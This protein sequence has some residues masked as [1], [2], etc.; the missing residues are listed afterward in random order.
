[1]P[2]DGLQETPLRNR[3][4]AALIAVLTLIASQ[5]AVTPVGAVVGQK[6]VIIV[7]PT[8]AQTDSYRSK[9]DDIATA[10]EAAGA[11][12]V[13]VYSPNAT[14]SAVRAAVDGANIVVYLGHGNG[15]PNPY[16]STELRDRTNGWGLNRTT[17]GG[18]SDD[19]SAQMVYCGEKALLGTLSSS[20]GAA[21][22]TYCTGGPITPAPNW[23]MIYSNACY[24]PGASEGSDPQGPATES[25]AMQR[26][27]NYSYPSLLL[28]GGAYF[29]TDMNN[30]PQQLIDTIL[31]NPG[32]AFGAIAENAN[33]YDLSRQRHYAHPDLSGTRIWIQNT[34]SPTSGNYFFA[35]AG[36][37]DL[38]PSG[39]TVAYTEPDVPSGSTDLIFDSTGYFVPGS[40]GASYVALAP[41][42]LL[43][44]RVAN[45]L[46]G[47]FGAGSPRTFQVTGRGGVPGNAT[48]IT[49]N[50][51]VTAQSAA[52]YVFLGPTPT[53]NPSSSTLNFPLGDSRA[54][55]VTVALGAGGTL[56]ATYVA[57]AGASTHLIFDV[58]GYFVPGSGGASFAPLAPARLL[59][60]RFGTGLSGPFG[61]GGPRT[62]QVTGLGGV[63]GNATAVTGNLTVTAQSK[64][65]YV[66]LGPDPVAS[67]AS[68]TLN[69]PLGDSRANGVTV[70]LGAGGTLSAT[71]VAPAGA[72]THLIFDVTG[73]FVPGSGGASYVALAPARLLDTRAG[74]GLSGP[75]FDGVPRSFQVTG[76]GGVPSNATAVTGNLTVTGQTADG[77]AFL[78]P[79][80]VAS[81][82]SSTLNFPVGDGRANGVTVALGAGGT[83]SATYIAP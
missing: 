46:S 50:L 13:K 67:P 27:R 12:V 57:P 4:R 79:D 34:G 62:F 59:D 43:D 22:R 48:A 31:N 9:G 69:F 80:P 65:G 24:A 33:G 75:F 19:W 17:A 18:D 51:T 35:Y 42:R 61:A 6:V 37:P 29:A 60:S 81:P 55:G 28:G 76:Q 68:S 2:V 10:A 53:S 52:G 70:A 40:S 21:Q 54:N 20:D 45:G 32:M 36:H 5:L 49:G 30:G 7:G 1:V 44:S 72:S 66:S 25:K 63:P 8:G 83:L 39:T 23:V 38:T 78:G 73:Y 56:S 58:T 64:A 41:A 74:T 71:Y 3:I 14:W 26:V 11:T 15:F 77:Y 47:A 82:A 16:G